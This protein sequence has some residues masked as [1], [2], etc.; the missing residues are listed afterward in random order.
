LITLK[1]LW[2]N[3]T[4]TIR[5]TDMGNDEQIFLK[6]CWY[7]A[8]WDHELLDGRKPARTILEKPVVLFRGASGKYVALDD[9]CCHRGAPLSM[10]RIEGDCLR[11]MYHGMK[12]DPSGAC[13]EVPGQDRIPKTLRVHSYPIVERG[14]LLWIWMGD[15]AL[16]DPA[17]IVDYPPLHD[18]AWRGLP[19]YL[20]YAANW[21]L[22]VDNLSDLAHLAFVHTNTLGGS[23]EYAYKS[24]PAG[25]DK[26][27][28]GFRVERWHRDSEPP[29]YHKKVI[30]TSEHQQRVDRRNR[31]TMTIPG[32]FFME[33][34]FSPAGSGQEDGEG[35][36][37]YR[38]AQY[39][40]PE[41]R[42]TTHF[43]WNYLHNYDIHDPNI[44]ISLRDSLIEG[45]YEDKAIIEAQQV[46]LDRDPD[47]RLRALEADA[48]LAH[49]RL[50]L[51]KHIK[52]ENEMAAGAP[53]K[54]IAG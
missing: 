8:A 18:P 16:A 34:L 52:Q 50:T 53:M 12:Y 46:L 28:D 5:E 20:H 3:E 32:M 44:A 37:Q 1:E 36:R 25:I 22:I 42:R 33:T 15:P 49:F 7:V 2:L 38:N 41:T 24:K 14:H 21:L 10:G 35:V 26:L 13:I 31:V 19:A 4:T 51:K 6:N 27:D 40:T 39:M 48:A 30:P 29:P 47:F 9:R 43:F 23:E 45:F 54:T 17:L 11:C